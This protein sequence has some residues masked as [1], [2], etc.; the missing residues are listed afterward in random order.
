MDDSAIQLIVSGV[1]IGLGVI[2]KR[3]VSN[4]VVE[5]RWIPLVLVVIGTP[6][7]A[8]IVKDWSVLSLASGFICAAS[9]IGIHQTAQQTSGKNL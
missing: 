9:A 3:A 6:L 2:L 8:G 1:L 5:N 4:E 7:Y